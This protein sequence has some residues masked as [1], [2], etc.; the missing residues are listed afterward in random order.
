MI[1]SWVLSII[2]GLEVLYGCYLKDQVAASM[3]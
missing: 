1:P 3:R 2:V